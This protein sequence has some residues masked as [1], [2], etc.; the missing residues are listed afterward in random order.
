MGRSGRGVATAVVVLLAVVPIAPVAADPADVRRAEEALGE[1]RSRRDDA[2]ARLRILQRRAEIAIEDHNEARSG[3][4]AVRVEVAEVVATLGTIQ[5]RVRRGTSS[6]GDF[7][8]RLYQ[9]GAA[10][11]LEALLG[12]GDVLEVQTRLVYL[13]SA[14]QA[15][16]NVVSLLKADREVELAQLSRLAEVEAEAVRAEAEARRTR[17]AVEQLL[18]AQQSELERLERGLAAAEQAQVEAER[19]EAERVA[20]ERA[21]AERRERERLAREAAA[22]AAAAPA[23]ARLT[24]PAVGSDAGRIAV[25]AAL[26]QLGKPYRW[27][28]AGPDDYDCSGLT[29]WAWAHAGVRLPHSSRMQYAATQRVTQTEAQPGDLIFFGS[30]IHHVGMYIGD[31]R[32]VEAPYTGSQVRLNDAFVRSDIVGIGRPVD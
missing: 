30:P 6:A 12:A 26:S 3:A 20:R 11:E 10:Y 28:A 2:G 5:A 24:G 27:G 9:H 18:D 4:D 21:E 15:Q 1:A 17:V 16:L 7:A 23:L 25:D 29:S 22:A 13:R 19:A 14:A 32:M 31:G 8:R